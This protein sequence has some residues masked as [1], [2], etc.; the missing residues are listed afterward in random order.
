MEKR[1][2][3]MNGWDSKTWIKQVRDVQKLYQKVGV[4]TREEPVKTSSSP[5]AAKKYLKS[6]LPVYKLVSWM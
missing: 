6:S 3:S 4:D 5:F 1:K 2:L